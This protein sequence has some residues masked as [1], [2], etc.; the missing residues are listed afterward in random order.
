MTTGHHVRSQMQHGWSVD[1][2]TWDRLPAWLVTTDQ[3][4]SVGFSILDANSVP[5]APGVYALC[6]SPP[7]RNVAGGVSPYDLFSILYTALYIGRTNNLRVRFQQHC[8]NPSPDVG[9]TRQTFGD[10]LEFW[11]CRIS[12][13]ELATIEAYLID[14]LG[15]SANQIRG[16]I[17]AT[18]QRPLPVDSGW[19]RPRQETS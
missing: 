12:G 2:A 3:W 1:R 18:I 9:R 10:S 6:S 17:A 13:G 14:C 8:Q 16:T 11:F 7:G 5:T 4:R 19:D 15:P